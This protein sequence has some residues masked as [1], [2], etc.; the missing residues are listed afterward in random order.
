[1][2]QLTILGWKWN[3]KKWEY[4][5]LPNEQLLGTFTGVRVLHR[6]LSDKEIK[7]IEKRE[8]PI[9]EREML[10]KME[11]IE[12]EQ[13]GYEMALEV[14]RAREMYAPFNSAHEGYA[15]LL[16]EVLELQAEVF[17]KTDLRSPWSMREE[18]TQIGAMA[19]RFIQDICKEKE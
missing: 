9:V 8:R 19:I 3:G 16:E 4:L 5:R 10:D 12:A 15:V 2:K 6:V 1:M 13:L 14:E 7:A 18:A 11:C 17:K